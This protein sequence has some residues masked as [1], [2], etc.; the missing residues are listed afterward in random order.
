[1]RY[2]EKSNGEIRALK[3]KNENNMASFWTSNAL[4]AR[5]VSSERKNVLMDFKNRSTE[6]RLNNSIVSA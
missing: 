3:L 1:M 2:Q 4:T 6:K 5:R